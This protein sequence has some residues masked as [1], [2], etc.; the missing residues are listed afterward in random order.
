MRQ[1]PAQVHACPLR[2]TIFASL[3]QYDE[4]YACGG[5]A[6]TYEPHVHTQCAQLR[7]E[8]QTGR[9]AANHAHVQRGPV[10]VQRRQHVYDAGLLGI[11]LAGLY[12]WKDRR[13]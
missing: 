11:L 4:S 2:S 7:G 8:R 9:A 5:S 6:R 3:S 1:C 10:H 13:G 12:V